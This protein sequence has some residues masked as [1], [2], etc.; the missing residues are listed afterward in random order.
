MQVNL[1]DTKSPRVVVPP[2][3]R[4]TVTL[5]VKKYTFAKS[6]SSGKD[7]IELLCEIAHPDSVELDGQKYILAG[8]EMTFYLGLS[9]EVKG[10]AKQSQLANTLEFHRKL[11]LPEEIDTDNLPYE[12]LLF[13]FWLTSTE[14]QLKRKT[15][16]GGDYEVILDPSTGKPRT[17][18][19]QWN[20]FVQNVLGPSTM[21]LDTPY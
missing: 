9:D 5:R 2:D 18:G 10:K 13:E 14:Q 17:L 4:D 6:K 11:G 12:N 21:K 8:Q 16:T 20:N 1:A 19:W 15:N 3:F 7:Q